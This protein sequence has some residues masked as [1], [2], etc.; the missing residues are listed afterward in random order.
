V[1]IQNVGN[2]YGNDI[3]IWSYSVG[4]M[5]QQPTQPESVAIQENWKLQTLIYIEQNTGEGISTEIMLFFSLYKTKIN[6]TKND[7]FFHP[8][9]AFKKV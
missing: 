7:L 1:Y 4:I 6:S 3:E 2:G 8:R 5:F 9:N